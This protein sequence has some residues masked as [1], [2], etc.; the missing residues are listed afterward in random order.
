MCASC[1]CGNV[2]YC[3]YVHSYA[4]MCSSTHSCGCMVNGW[5]AFCIGDNFGIS[6][7]A[8]T[9]MC[10]YGTRP[11]YIVNLNLLECP[12]HTVTLMYNTLP[13]YIH[14]YIRIY[15]DCD[16]QCS[17]S[18]MQSGLQHCC[19]S[20][21]AGSLYSRWSNSFALLGYTTYRAYITVI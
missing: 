15:P 17:P 18:C 19:W 20:A 14:T 8:M 6:K 5:D 10:Y 9:V 13:M 16:Y 1:N 11:T 12:L 3:I 4:Y 2:H 7:S 21:G